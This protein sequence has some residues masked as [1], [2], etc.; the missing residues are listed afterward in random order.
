MERFNDVK[1]QLKNKKDDGKKSQK[2]RRG[3]EER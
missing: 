1:K 2:K 3:K